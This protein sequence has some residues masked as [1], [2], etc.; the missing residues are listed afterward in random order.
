MPHWPERLGQGL[1]RIH[2]TH[3]HR[4]ENPD[5]FLHAAFCLHEL[6]R[7]AEAKSLLLGGADYLKGNPVFYYNLACYECRLGEL[8]YA[9]ELLEQAMSMDP[10][11]KTMWPND[12]DLAPLRDKL[13]G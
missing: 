7:T 8:D 10:K 5:G 13:R 11:F 3:R 1:G 9:G 6:G 2:Q 4:T 12:P